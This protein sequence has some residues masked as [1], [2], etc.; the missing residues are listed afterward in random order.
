MYL[1]DVRILE[2]CRLKDRQPKIR[3]RNH[4]RR[5]ARNREP[6]AEQ[7]KSRDC[8]AESSVMCRLHGGRGK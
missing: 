3:V 6:D 7:G 8:D 4:D 5:A 1:R 2:V